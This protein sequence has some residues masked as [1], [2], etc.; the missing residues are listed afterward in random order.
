MAL[1]NS[2]SQALGLG[3][4]TQQTHTDKRT[5]RHTH[6]GTHT[7]IHTQANRRTQTRTST[8]TPHTSFLQE[9]E[10][11]SKLSVDDILA[12]N[13]RKLDEAR[14]KQV[15]APKPTPTSL[16]SR[17]HTH[18]HTTPSLC[19]GG[20]AAA[21]DPGEAEAARGAEAGTGGGTSARRGTARVHSR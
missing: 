10:R 6:I 16:V 1:I 4:H 11:R 9:K 14:R 21:R 12:E 8:L 5:D 17:W 18:A 15:C 2:Q 13:Q 20:G 7:Q 3:C 19:T